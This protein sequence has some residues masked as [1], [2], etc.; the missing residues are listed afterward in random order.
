M[1][2]RLPNL[3]I[4]L[5]IVIMLQNMAFAVTRTASVRVNKAVLHQKITGFGGFVNSPQ[6]GYNYMTEAEI[7]KLWGKNS[8]A[9]YNIMRLYL[10]I[11]EANWSQSLNTAKLAKSL[12]LKIFATP[13]SMPS[14]WKTNNTIASVFVENGVKK[15]VYLK[16]EHYLDYANYLNNYVTYLKNNGVELDAISI[17]NEPD[18]QV[19]YAGCIWTPAQMAK[20]IKEYAHLINCKV[21]A[22]EGVGITDNYASAFLDQGVLNNFEIFAGHQ[23]GAIQSGLK[24]VQAQGK[25]V[26][27]TE[28]LINWIADEGA[29][30]NVSW[31]KDAF[32]FANKLNDALL[33]NVNAWVHYASK[34]YYGLMGDGTF[35][36]TSGVLTKR[37]YVL[38]HFAKYVTG[39]TRIESTWN[40]ES[41]VLKGSSYLSQ[42][43]DSVFVFLINSSND[44]YSL[45]VDL[46]FYTKSGKAVTTTETTDLSEVPVSYAEESLRPKVTIAPSSITT[47]VFAKSSDRA[48][49]QMTGEPVFYDK[50]EKQP[51]TN[52]AFGTAY[53]LSGK[54]ALFKN[55]NPLISSNTNATN[56]YL[57]LDQPFNRL[58]FRV[59]SLSSTLNYSS[60][61]TTLYYINNAGAV[62]SYNYGNITFDKRND[63]DWVFDISTN[64]LTDGCTGIIGLRN[65]NFSSALTFNFAD[66]Y[67]SFGNEK[68]F[69]FRGIYSKDDSNLLECLDDIAY[70]S[71][72]FSGTTGLTTETDWNR[73]AANKNSVY[74]VSGDLNSTKA[75]VISGSTCNNLILT[76]APGNFYSPLNFSATSAS[77]RFASD[78]YKMI[79]LPFDANIPEGLKA[80]TLEVTDSNVVAKPITTG[81]ISSNTPFL[82]KGIGEFTF[83]GSGNVSSPRVVKAGSVNGVYIA[84]RVPTS[85]YY[86]K[87]EADKVYFQRVQAG[88]QIPASAFS[89]YLSPASTVTASMLPLTLEEAPLVQARNLTIELDENGNALISAAQLDSGSV[90]YSGP[91]QLKTDRSSFS[92]SDIGSVVPVTLTG[93]DGK[94]YTASAIGYITV[95]DTRKPELTT[96]AAQTFCFSNAGYT[97]PVLQARDNCGIA[98]MSYTISGATQRSGQNGDASGM[99]NAGTSTIEWLVTDLSGNIA[100]DTTLVS[101][102]SAFTA[103]IPDVYAGSSSTDQKNTLYL[104][105][106]SSSL[107]LT[108]VPD[109]G[110]AP[111][112]YTWSNGEIASSIKATQAGTYSVV[113]SDA[114]GCQTTAS[115]DIRVED[116]RCGNNNDKVLLCHNGTNICVSSSAV[117][118]H[119]AH[120]DNLGSCVSAGT[121]AIATNNESK[122]DLHEKKFTVYPNPVSSTLHFKLDNIVMGAK[123]EIYNLNG[124]EALRLPLLSG[125]E[126]VIP[127]AD[128][129]SGTYI[130]RIINGTEIISSR[131][132]KN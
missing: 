98:S 4:F 71:L 39:A 88:A 103:V 86:L 92:C 108:A 113:I 124:S 27:M 95:K 94:G 117:K 109:G 78:G 75:N 101:V 131:F 11:G 5:G 31:V 132:V 116:V 43:G 128:L 130:L 80:Y 114:K 106:G 54:T 87:K 22:P 19:E 110:T 100:K 84:G 48:I 26:W 122:D 61:N 60:S 65:G 58:V 72:D 7:R 53:T 12:G 63:F 93:I 33:A 36:T 23:Y 85:G 18:Y 30:R 121:L 38:S 46:P 111:Y 74:Y 9:G 56:G 37:G 28:F 3:I 24:N 13:W 91:L 112:T 21:I 29:S 34:R 81:K 83:T 44:S 77:Y 123:A 40:D 59:K 32:S 102:N 10:P 90:S 96:P 115:I 45:T 97:L 17:Q 42:S 52:T 79:V 107:S 55:D 126:V 125:P 89:A 15:N 73:A 47:L 70:T 119:L 68:G 6:F 51:V 35:G 76:D 25:E 64:T 14:E 16:E 49:S 62:R 99:F 50:I 82:A 20:F 104:G 8:E 1:K 118:A 2:T 129:A 105:Y 120:G 41:N 69:K 57:K 66:V 127:V 67:F